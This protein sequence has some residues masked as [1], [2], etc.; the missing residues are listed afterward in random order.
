MDLNQYVTKGVRC[1]GKGCD[2]EVSGPAVS[3][4]RVY[5]QQA[6]ALGWTLWAARGTRAY[7]PE[8]GPQPG[9]RMSELTGYY[10]SN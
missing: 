8:H 10:R 4:N 9:H 6:V 7:C 1:D 5:R 3:D 2:A